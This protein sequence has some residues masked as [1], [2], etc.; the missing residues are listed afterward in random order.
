MSGPSG[1]PIAI[2]SFCKQDYPLKE[3]C[4][5]FVQSND[6]SLNSFCVMS[7]FPCRFGV[8]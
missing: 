8:I 3:K 7:P 5:Y 6:S 2:T 1:D 4:A